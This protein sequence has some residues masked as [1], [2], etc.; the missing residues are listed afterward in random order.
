[1][2]DGASPSVRW[3]EGSPCE[4]LNSR[5]LRNF[6]TK[7]VV[8]IGKF[9]PLLSTIDDSLRRRAISVSSTV[10]TNWMTTNKAYDLNGVQAWPTMFFTRRWDAMSTEGPLVIDYLKR[11]KDEQSAIIE[12]GIATSSKSASGLYESGFDLFA[13]QNESLQKLVKFIETTLSSAVCIANSQEARPQDLQIEFVDSWYHITNEGGF[14]DAHVHHGCSWCGIF[15]L[16]L[17]DSENVRAKSAPNGGSRFYCP[18]NLGGAYRDY[19]NKY[20]T[21]SIDAPMENGLLLL[22]PSY[23]LHSGLPYRGKQDRVVIAF[24][25]KAFVKTG[26][27][28]SERLARPR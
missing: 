25:A 16:Q 15:Y 4:W 23:L 28:S 22:F 11:L 9:L 18:F 26:T 3:K 12:S 13:Q 5:K 14:H 1:M 21:S 24:N 8:S 7:P 10:C 2:S 17:G 6:L 27:L 20:L 19:G